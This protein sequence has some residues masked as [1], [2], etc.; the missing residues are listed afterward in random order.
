MYGK[1]I[2]TK[3]NDGIDVYGEFRTEF[4]YHGGNVRLEISADSEYAVFING[5][6]VYSGQYADFPWYKIYDEIEIGEY[7]NFGKN[8]LTVWVWRCGEVNFC[9]YVNRAAVRFAV[10]VDRQAVSQSDGATFS[11]VLPDFRSGGQKQITPQMGFSFCADGRVKPSDF[12]RSVEL[13]DMP[14]ELYLRPISRLKILEKCTAK[15]I[16]ESVYDLGRERVGLPFIELCAPYGEEIAVT[17]GERLTEEGSVPRRIGIRDFSFTVIGN[18]ETMRVFNPLRKLGLRYFEVSGNCTVYEIGVIPLEYPFEEIKRK[19]ADERRQ[20]IYDVAVRT[21]KLNAFEHYFDCPWREQAFYALD[22]RFQMRYGYSAFST[23]EYPYAAL[24]L[25]SEDRNP[26]GFVSMVVPSSCKMVIPS[27]ALFY[28]IAME[29]YAAQTGDIRLIENYFDKMAQVMQK[30]MEN[31]KK[32]LVQ[33]FQEEGVWNFYEWNDVLDGS[34]FLYQEDCALNLNY[35]LALQS[36][37]KICKTLGKDGARYEN[38]V[39]DVKRRINAK[40]FDETSGLYK[41]SETSQGF[42]ELCNA[43]A[44]LTETA[45]GE[46]AEKI[47]AILADKESGLVECTLS[48]ISFKYDAL[49]KVDKKKYSAYVLNDIDKKYSYMLAEGATSFWETMKGWR[50]FDNAGSLCH[51]WAALPVYY[52]ALLDKAV[53]SP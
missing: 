5:N 24:K 36:M 3:E 29:E 51:G 45:T 18:G 37:V 20:K 15:R 30:F 48:M 26:M 34:N 11:R 47:C 43:Y 25:M 46:R 39:E 50:D 49:L 33:N 17:F 22:S 53:T 9:H 40:Y 42:T 35:L 6:F 14:E 21:L 19:F 1:W 8:L 41:L 12:E 13:T 4:D 23:T 2:W 10:T 7:V 28:V 38:E 32:G 31:K 44:V 27:F 16:S 52:Y